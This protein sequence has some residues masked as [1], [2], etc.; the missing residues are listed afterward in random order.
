MR[1]ICFFLMQKL[2]RSE[3]Q[4]KVI[5]EAEEKYDSL[6]KALDPDLSQSC[7]KR[8]EEATK[9]GNILARRFFNE[10]FNYLILHGF[11]YDLSYQYFA[12]FLYNSSKFQLASF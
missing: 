10:S 12:L 11:T 3:F 8:C 1:Q 9:E 6:L 5:T 2:T 7:Q 4:A